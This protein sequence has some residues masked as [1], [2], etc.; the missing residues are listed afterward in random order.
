MITED[1][2]MEKEICLKA[3]VC[4][5]TSSN[6]CLA[7][8]FICGGGWFVKQVASLVTIYAN[9]FT[10]NSHLYFKPRMSLTN[11]NAEAKTTN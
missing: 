5:P 11:K 6:V 4:L 7:Q 10:T 9:A 3:I 2:K 8:R 1:L